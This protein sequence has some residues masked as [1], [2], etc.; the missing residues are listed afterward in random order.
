M[1]DHLTPGNLDPRQARGQA[2]GRREPQRSVWSVL[3]IVLAVLLA[4]AGLVV[5]GTVVLLF[6]AMSNFGSNK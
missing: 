1:T 4:V 6:V 2:G 5:V 3:G